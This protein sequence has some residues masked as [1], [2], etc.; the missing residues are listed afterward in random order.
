MNKLYKESEEEYEIP[1]SSLV[2]NR[3]HCAGNK[4]GEVSPRTITAL[5]VPGIELSPP[6]AENVT[7]STTY[8]YYDDK[9]VYLK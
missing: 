7:E 6:R 1:C 2:L 9:I 4:D 3:P 8:M 5:A